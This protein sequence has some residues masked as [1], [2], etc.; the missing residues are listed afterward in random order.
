[1]NC[2]NCFHPE[3]NHKNIDGT[4][5]AIC[6]ATIGCRCEEFT[7]NDLV[8][9]ANEIELIKDECSEIYDRCKYVL[10]KI[11]NSRKAG[12]KS[13]YKIYVWVWHDFKIKNGTELNGKIWKTLPNQDTCNREKRR[14]KQ[15]HPELQTTDKIIIS[16]QQARFMANMEMAIGI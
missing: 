10:E 5:K 2:G 3:G 12:E 6:N 15:Q 13:F 14:V 1:M 7:P 9:F 11:P 16:H 4:N 8:E